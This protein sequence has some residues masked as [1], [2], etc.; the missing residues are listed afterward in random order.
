MQLEPVRDDRTPRYPTSD[1]LET[2]P[3]LLEVVPERWRRNPYVRRILGGVLCLLLAHEAA[4]SGDKHQSRIAPLFVHGEG[5]GSF[6]CE[7]VN[8][9]VFLSEAEARQ[10]IQEEAR[11]AGL[12]FAPGALTLGRSQ[13]M[14]GFD[15][16]HNVAYGFVSGTDTES[17]IPRSYSSVQTVATKDAAARLRAGLGDTAASPWI[18]IFYEPATPEKPGAEELRAQVRDFIGWLKA[19]GVI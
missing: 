15:R 18:G 4:C 5:R 17:W 13:V 6:G 14:D 19:Q 1:Y 11:R 3:E 9:P 7:A 16:K 12:E 10:V 8:P 2:H